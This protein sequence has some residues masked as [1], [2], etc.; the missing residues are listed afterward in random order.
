VTSVYQWQGRICEDAE[1]LLMIKT[2][3]AGYP[4]LEMRLKTLHPY[5]IPEIVAI[6]ILTGSRQYLEWL[7]TTVNPDNAASTPLSVHPP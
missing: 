3:P 4:A 5:E 7:G 6:P 2:T 1:Q